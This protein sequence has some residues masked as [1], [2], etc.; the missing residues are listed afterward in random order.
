MG[1][2]AQQLT[3]GIG[4]GRLERAR[5]NDGQWAGLRPDGGH[6]DRQVA[7]MGGLSPRRPLI[8]HQSKS[9]ERQSARD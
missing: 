5:R 7:I 9:S 3:Y 6:A 2:P 1:A 4:L 8:A